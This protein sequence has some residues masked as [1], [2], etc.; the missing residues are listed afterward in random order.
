VNDTLPAL[1]VREERPMA[2]TA[3]RYAGGGF[4]VERVGPVVKS[5]RYVAHAADYV[6]GISGIVVYEIT[7]DG[8]ISHMWKITG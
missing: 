7:D 1:A 5:G 4:W 2:Q 3:Q 8:M 6:G